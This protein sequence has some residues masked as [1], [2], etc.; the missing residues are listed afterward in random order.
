MPTRSDI[1]ISAYVDVDIYETVVATEVSVSLRCTFVRLLR[2]AA[3]L[4]QIFLCVCT[5]IVF[6]PTLY[7]A[8]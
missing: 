4:D 3:V 5:N 6:L 2:K 7:N 8:V 1:C